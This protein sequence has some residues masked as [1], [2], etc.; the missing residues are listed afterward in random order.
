MHNQII[1]MQGKGVQQYEQ[2]KLTFVK[3]RDGSFALLGVLLFCILFVSIVSLYM[4]PCIE[5]EDIVFLIEITRAKLK[6]VASLQVVLW[7]V[8]A[9]GSNWFWRLSCCG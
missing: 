6:R 8:R 9:M 5:L 2:E 3:I 7:I 4:I 1:R